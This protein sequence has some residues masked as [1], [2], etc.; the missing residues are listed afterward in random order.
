MID[1]AFLEEE[2]EGTQL[3]HAAFPAGEK[4]P[5]HCRVALSALLDGSFEARLVMVAL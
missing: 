5:P 3:R 1:Q 2:E 4:P